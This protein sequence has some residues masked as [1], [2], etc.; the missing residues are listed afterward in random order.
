MKTLKIKF[1]DNQEHQ[2]NAIRSVVRLFDGYSKRDTTFQMYGSDTIA[3][4]DPYEMLDEQW[5]FDNLIQAQKEN[6]LTED[7]YLNF[8]DGF[9]LI[10][11]NS[12]RYPYYTV[13]METGT[14]KTYVYLR[15]I[16]ELR[17]KYGWGKYIIIV[18]SVAIYEG[19]L[20]TL[21]ITREH[22]DT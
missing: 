4:M 14:G 18:P 20:K 13:E 8:D 3:N 1:E 10:D 15:T 19:V 22:F 6:G 17:K 9:E 7:M 12:W 5:L 2:L 11:I 16:L 21:K